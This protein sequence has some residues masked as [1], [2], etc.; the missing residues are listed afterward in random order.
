MATEVAGQAVSAIPLTD[1][2]STSDLR[3]FS[4]DESGRFLKRAIADP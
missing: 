1:R 4:A 3:V 2:Y